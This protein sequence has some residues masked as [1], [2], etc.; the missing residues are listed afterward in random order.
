MESDETP[1]IIEIYKFI[2]KAVGS[3]HRIVFPLITNK[4]STEHNRKF[5]SYLKEF[6]GFIFDIIEKKEIKSNK[7]IEHNDLLSTMLKLSEQ[8]G[9]HYDI[10]SL[11]DEMVSFFVAGHDS[12]FNQFLY[13]S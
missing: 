1:H 9:V 3:V 6:D 11:R 8:D 2:I 7:D 10:K 5:A 4:L 13:H 12:K